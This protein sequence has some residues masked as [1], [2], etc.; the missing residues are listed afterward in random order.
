MSGGDSLRSSPPRSS[1]LDS[2]PVVIGISLAAVAAVGAADLLASR[3]MQ[4]TAFYLLPIGFVSWRLGRLAGVV[5]SGLCLAVWLGTELWPAQDRPEPSV[6]CWTSV[7]RLGIFLVACCVL[8][9]LRRALDEERELARTD[10]VTGTAN[11]RS[12]MESL[13]RELERSRRNG[14]PFTLAYLDLDN[15]KDVNDRLGHNAGDAVL[16][17]VAESVATALRASDVVARL[18]GDEFGVIL[19]ETGEAAADEVLGRLRERALAAMHEGS[20][21]LTLSIGAITF[22]T[23]P[24]SADA[25]LKLADAAMYAVKRAGKDAVRRETHGA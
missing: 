8:S 7:T 4:F 21:Q 13:G 19:P 16:R 17:K 15:F 3:Q 2:K 24:E 5:F 11:A 10:P 18:G 1:L 12:F 14:Q 9:R 25:A 20:M 23:M 22:W 6:L